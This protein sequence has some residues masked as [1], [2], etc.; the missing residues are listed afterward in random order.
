M[1]YTLVRGITVEPAEDGRIDAHVEVHRSWKA[2]WAAAITEYNLRTRRVERVFLSADVYDVNRAGNG[3]AVYSLHRYGDGLYEISY[4]YRSGRIDRVYIAVIN[5][6]PT[7]LGTL[8]GEDGYR[9]FH[10]AI[11]ACRAYDDLLP[12]SPDDPQDTSADA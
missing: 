2:G 4:P 6:Q 9:E 12:D 7:I 10:S 1:K 5:G 8:F 11:D 3:R